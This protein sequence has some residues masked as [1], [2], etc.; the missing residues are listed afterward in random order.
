MPGQPPSLHQLE[1]GE[2]PA[3][4][5]R[6]EYPANDSWVPASSQPSL[7][8]RIVITINIPTSQKIEEKKTLTQF[9]P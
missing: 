3:S 7:S 5:A 4:P 2:R 1:E 8:L 6:Q 9:V